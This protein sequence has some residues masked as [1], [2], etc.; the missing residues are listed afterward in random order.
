MSDC[1]KNATIEKIKGAYT[2]ILAGQ[3]IGLPY[4]TQDYEHSHILQD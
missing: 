4:E 2:V 3:D 1:I